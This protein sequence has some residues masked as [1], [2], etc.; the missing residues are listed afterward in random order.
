MQNNSLIAGK[1]FDSNE[2]ISQT[3]MESFFKIVDWP[4]FEKILTF[5]HRGLYINNI[6]GFIDYATDISYISEMDNDK[7]RYT[8]IK[9]LKIHPIM[10]NGRQYFILEVIDTAI[11]H[12]H[13]L[14]ERMILED[15]RQNNMSLVM[16][17][18]HGK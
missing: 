17:E 18:N 13:L 1:V 2:G 4:T 10:I 15:L 11:L 16:G 7:N 12:K 5:S 3:Y 14:D 6:G 9:I 8:K